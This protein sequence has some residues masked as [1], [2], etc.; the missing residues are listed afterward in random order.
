MRVSAWDLA[1]VKI[2]YQYPK[3]ESRSEVIGMAGIRELDTK[4]HH[5]H[6]KGVER[7]AEEVKLVRRGGINI[8]LDLTQI[9]LPLYE[10]GL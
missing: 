6:K 5:T 7:G 2:S 8:E 1:K 4:T 10:M 3:F 9:T